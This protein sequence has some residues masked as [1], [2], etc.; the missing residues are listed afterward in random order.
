MELELYLDGTRID[1]G[2]AP[3][4]AELPRRFPIWKGQMTPGAHHLTT[5]VVL[6]GRNRGIFT[7][8]DG[9]TTRVEANRSFFAEPQRAV[10]LTVTAAERRGVTT[11]LMEKPDV[12][13]TGDVVL[14]WRPPVV[15]A[16][17][18]PV[19]ER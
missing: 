19:V 18:D 1:H 17:A 12:V 13:I 11:P 10:A 15:T 9:Y 16:P 6:R 14:G 5:I 3:S 8:L 2:A 7:Y 4:G